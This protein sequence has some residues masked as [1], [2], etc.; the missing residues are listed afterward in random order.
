MLFNSKEDVMEKK[1]N[2]QTVIMISLAVALIISL[3]YIAL[4]WYQNYIS[5]QQ[6]TIFQQGYQQGA[7][8]GYQQAV[9]QLLNQ[10]STCKTVPVTANNVTLNLI[11][12]ECLQANQ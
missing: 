8:Y 9:L 12:T 11:A 7:V 3:S 4:G 10:A 5:Q 2:R 6:N 1:M